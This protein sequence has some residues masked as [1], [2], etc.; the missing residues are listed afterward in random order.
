VTD[1]VMFKS[2]STEWETPPVLFDALD[3]R[4]HFSL[5]VCATSENAKCASYYTVDDDALSQPWTGN[6]WCNPP[7]ARDIPKFL[8]KARKELEALQCDV[9]VCLLPA[10]TDTK[11]FHS[12]VWDNVSHHPRTG[13]SV[14]FLS[15]RLRFVGAP[16]SA[17]FPSMLVILRPRGKEPCL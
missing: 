11:W 1:A 10:R 8:G 4:F 12:Y 3:R 9:V 16:S 5:D 13:V 15:G 17:P 2:Q 6:V 14:E 7:Y